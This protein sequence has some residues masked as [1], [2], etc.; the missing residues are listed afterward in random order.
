[1]R[2]RMNQ[3]IIVLGS[4][5]LADLRD[6]IDCECSRHG[7]YEDISNRPQQQH[8][9]ESDIDEEDADYSSNSKKPPAA[10]KGKANGRKPKAKPTPKSPPSPTGTAVTQYDPGF[11]F[12]TDTFYTDDRHACPAGDYTA[13]IREWAANHPG[14]VGP[15][16]PDTLPMAAT[17]LDAIRVRLGAAQVYQ[18][19]GNCEHVF[20]VSDVRLLGGGDARRRTDYP[21]VDVVTL[22]QWKACGTCA[23]AEARVMVRDSVWHVDDPTYLCEE[24]FRSLHYVDGRKVGEFRAYEFVGHLGVSGG[25][26]QNNGAEIMN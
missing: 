26:M 2:L 17:R 13:P 23:E 5:T 9:P 20:C 6:R 11:F 8:P 18:H 3:R 25:E 10:T 16:E 22:R 19:A 14:D 4:Q 21:L 7:P 1:M 12:I 15:L 24:C